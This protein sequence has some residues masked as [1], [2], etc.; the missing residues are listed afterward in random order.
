MIREYLATVQPDA[1]HILYESAIE[2]TLHFLRTDEWPHEPLN[3]CAFSYPDKGEFRSIQITSLQDI[4]E[5]K[6]PLSPKEQLAVETAIQTA[7]TGILHHLYSEIRQFFRLTFPLQTDLPFELSIDK[8]H[9]SQTGEL[10]VDESLLIDY[11][12][13]QRGHQFDPYTVSVGTPDFR[14]WLGIILPHLVG[15]NPYKCKAC[16]EWWGTKTFRVVSDNGFV[17]HKVD[18]TGR[19]YT[20]VMIDTE[21]FFK[22]DP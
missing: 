9:L 22:E 15:P 5:L 19:T 18:E 16:D 3:L 8:A 21:N 11:S 6:A 2:D 13:T 1:L 4:Q 7:L 14:N 12:V 17:R 10:H 20:E